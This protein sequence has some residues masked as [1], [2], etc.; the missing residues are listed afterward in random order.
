MDDGK[1]RF[2][3]SKLNTNVTVDHLGSKSPH[4]NRYGITRFAMKLRTRYFNSAHTGDQHFTAKNYV[5]ANCNNTN[6]NDDTS[7]LDIL[8]DLSN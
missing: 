6:G 5:S 3:V 8:N 4:S 1:E 2:T 7:D